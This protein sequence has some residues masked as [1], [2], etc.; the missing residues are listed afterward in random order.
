MTQTILV[1][2]GPNLNMLGLREPE[3]YG[4][5][6]LKDVEE[7][8]RTAAAPFA[9]TCH[10]SNHEGVLIEHVHDAFRN[11]DVVGVVINAGAFTHTSVA[12]HDALKMLK[13]P[14]AEVHITDPKKREAF[15]HV[16]YIEPVAFTSICGQGTAGYTQAMDALRKKISG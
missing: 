11:P 16:S 10:Q 5:A 13:C 12:L 8:C 7:L 14:I 9:V 15:R 1:L 2:H 4:T 6:T 3:L